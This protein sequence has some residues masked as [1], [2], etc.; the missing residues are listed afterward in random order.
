M[1]D[2]TI[3]NDSIILWYLFTALLT[4][5]IWIASAMP[6]FAIVFINSLM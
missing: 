5:V 3:I 6:D 4:V 1:P 2:F